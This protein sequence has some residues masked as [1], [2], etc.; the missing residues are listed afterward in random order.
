MGQAQESMT[1]NM[2]A[3]L[4]RDDKLDNMLKKTETMSDLSYSISK[5]VRRLSTPSNQPVEKSKE[6]GPAELRDG[7]DNSWGRVLGSN[8]HHLRHVMRL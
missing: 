1:K 4:E 3:L 5:K 2:Q 7:K 6:Q 8:L